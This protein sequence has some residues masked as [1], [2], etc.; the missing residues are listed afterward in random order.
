MPLP[1]QPQR[2]DF[3]TQEAF[4]EA[5]GFWYSRV[6]R[7]SGMRGVKRTAPSPDSPASSAAS[8]P[9]STPPQQK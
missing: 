2:Q 1:S 8:V 3:P 5:L 7:L 6:G 4:E 9:A